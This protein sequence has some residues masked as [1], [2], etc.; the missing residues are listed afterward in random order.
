MDKIIICNECFKSNKQSEKSKDK[1][2]TAKDGKIVLR[3]P[4]EPMA[5]VVRERLKNEMRKYRK[6]QNIVEHPFG[7]IKRTMNFPTFL[8][9]NLKW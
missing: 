4:N 5:E 7:I 2:T 6:R 1:C 9:G 8:P 3:G